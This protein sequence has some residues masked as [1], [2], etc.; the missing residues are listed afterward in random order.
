MFMDIF[1]LYLL[2]SKH[3][4]YIVEFYQY[5]LMLY[6]LGP[7]STSKRRHKNVYILSLGSEARD[8][9]LDP[10]APHLTMYMLFG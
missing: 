2:R 3:G 1:Q 8:P 9:E 10:L 6:F 5:V 7:V 4:Y